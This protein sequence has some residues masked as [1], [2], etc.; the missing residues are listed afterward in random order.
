MESNFAYQSVAP[1]LKNL[2]LVGYYQIDP[3]SPTLYKYLHKIYMRIGLIWICGYTVLQALKILEARDDMDKVMATLFLFLSHTDSIYKQIVFSLKADQ[4][5]QLLDILRGEL[6]NQR[7]HKKQLLT[8]ARYSVI[9]LSIINAMALLTCF[10]WVVIPVI[11]HVQ[12]ETV[13]YE[14]WLPFQYNSDL[15]FYI[16]TIVVWISTSSLAFGNTT[17]DALIAFLL[18]QCQTQIRILRVELQNVV[19]RSIEEALASGTTFE[20]VLMRRFK[21][22]LDHHNEIMKFA[23]TVE[24]IF[25]G[26][27]FYLFLV[28][29]WII[30]TSLY[31]IVD[32]TP[33]SVQFF[34]M[35]SYLFCI[36]LEL[37]IYCFYGGEVTF[38]SEN[39]TEYIY[40]M[41][42][43]QTPVTHRKHMIILMERVKRPIQPMAGNIIPL[44][45]DTFVKIMK[46]SYSF[47]T[48]LKA[49]NE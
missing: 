12:G 29:G 26:P 7:E 8:T 16:I 21:A 36:L 18:A 22:I 10:L 47:F 30:C 5:E 23:K 24:D 41:D 28:G 44:S 37:F 14:I 45:N 20:Q 48:L 33:T 32:M 11:R 19:Q 42:W 15:T 49:T 9:L 40:C 2:R 1:H 38:E 34:S 25:S 4:V 13:E 31:R 46:S 3:R 27:I 43:L 39:L 17:M 35:T 6:Y